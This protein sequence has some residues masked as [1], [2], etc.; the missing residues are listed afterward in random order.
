ME[1]QWY[2]G[3]MAKALRV[4]EEYLPLVDV[5]VELLDARIPNSSSNPEL[6][7]RIGGRPRLIALNKADLADPAATVEWIAAFRQ[8]DAQAVAIEAQ[9]GQGVGELLRLAVELASA[10]MARERARGR[11]PRRARF[12]IVGIPNVGKSSLINRL[13]GRASA[14][15]GAHPGV[16]RGVQWVR[17]RENL[18]LLDLP[19]VLWP[20]F[21]DP[22]VG[23]HLAATGAIS[24]QV[25][26]HYDVARRLVRELMPMAGTAIAAR[27]G[28]SELPAT[29]EELLAE[30]GR[31]RGCLRSGGAVDLAAAAD[32]FLREFRLGRL[33]R[34]TLERAVTAE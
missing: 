7:K 20:K 8:D 16:T 6:R 2:P 21:E 3:H 13:T 19:G 11:R 5:V 25:Y 14:R 4:L 29:A 12:M 18:E 32:I 26:D 34:L 24:E 27:F 1:V 17:V 22:R 15:T 31:R 9:S 30:I 33:G 28:M 10:R 23:F